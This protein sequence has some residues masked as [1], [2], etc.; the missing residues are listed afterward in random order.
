MRPGSFG[1]GRDASGVRRAHIRSL[2]YRQASGEAKHD[3]QDTR[4][5]A[6]SSENHCGAAISALD[7]AIVCFYRLPA[8][9]SSRV[10]CTL[11]EDP[12][13]TDLSDDRSRH[14][15]VMLVRG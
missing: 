7:C 6:G 10:A 9:R 8:N 14:G 5:E 1:E 4:N 2:R 15:S 11:D 3:G 12:A 13:V